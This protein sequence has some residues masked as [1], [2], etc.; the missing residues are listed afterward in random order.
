MPSQVQARFPLK[1]VEEGVKRPLYVDQ[2]VRILYGIMSLEEVER[3]LKANNITHH[4][5]GLSGGQW[6]YAQLVQDKEVNWKG[7]DPQQFGFLIH[8]NNQYLFATFPD[9]TT[10]HVK[11]L[12][13]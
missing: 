3:V 13:G 12:R 7:F 11:V 10:M 6:G 5:A 8:Y 2:G 9:A 4:S 1:G